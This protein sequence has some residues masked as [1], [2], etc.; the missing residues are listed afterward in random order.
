MNFDLNYL[1]VIGAAIA[2][3]VVNALW[4]SVILKGQVA[5]LRKGDATIAGRDPAPPMY[6]VAMIGQLL[7]AFVLAVMLR[8]TGLSGLVGGALVGVFLWLGF[9]INAVTQL[10]V[11]GYRDRRFAVID[12]LNWLIAAIVMGAILG[13]WG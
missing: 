4:Y 8:T 13:Q 5:A 7:M 2:G 10:H 1:A 3:V 11:F 12:G 9:T 6:A